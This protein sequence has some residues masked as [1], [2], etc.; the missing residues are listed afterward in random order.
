VFALHYWHQK[1]V[2][3]RH[4]N[5][6]FCKI[7]LQVRYL[8]T[9]SVSVSL[10]YNRIVLLLDNFKTLWPDVALI[11]MCEDY[12]HKNTVWHCLSCIWYIFWKIKANYLCLYNCDLYYRWLQRSLQYG[13]LVWGNML[14]CWQPGYFVAL[15]RFL[16]VFWNSVFYKDFNTIQFFQ[17]MKN[18]TVLSL[19]SV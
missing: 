14:G 11:V 19:S 9:S 10:A 5:V 8:G 4:D 3:S 15:W 18:Q 16:W 13:S 6:L 17:I 2:G 7:W 12:I 1:S